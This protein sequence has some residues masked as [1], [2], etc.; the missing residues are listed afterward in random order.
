LFAWLRH[1]NA[2]N[3]VLALGQL[4]TALGSELKFS[5]SG[6]LSVWALGIAKQNGANCFWVH[7]SSL[8]VD[9]K[10]IFRQ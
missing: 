10:S 2:N 6:G 3:S 4:I 1:F 7:R 5:Q 8:P 9:G